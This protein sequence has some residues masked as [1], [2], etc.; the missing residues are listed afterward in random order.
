MIGL[1]CIP[2]EAFRNGAVAVTSA[3][4]QTLFVAGFVHAEPNRRTEIRAAA[5]RRSL[6]AGV[7][8]SPAVA[9]SK[10]WYGSNDWMN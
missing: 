5:N 7:D 6:Q 10:R 4:T 9:N 3:V 1:F 8:S 2:E